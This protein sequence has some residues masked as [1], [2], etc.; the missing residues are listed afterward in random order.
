MFM[1]YSRLL[2]PPSEIE[3]ALS[4]LVIPS[5]AARLRMTL[6]GLT[7]KFSAKVRNSFAV[8]F[9]IKP[10]LFKAVAV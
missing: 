7:S 5:S 4:V 1:V 2:P 9:I 6:S 3:F 8:D 10:W